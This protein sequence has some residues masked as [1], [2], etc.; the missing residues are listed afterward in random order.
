MNQWISRP[1]DPIELFSW[2]VAGIF[3]LAGILIVVKVLSV[4]I[5][6]LLWIF[7]KRTAKPVV[8]RAPDADGQGDP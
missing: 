7:K 3:L 6:V 1:V 5:K 8:D 2:A 4:M